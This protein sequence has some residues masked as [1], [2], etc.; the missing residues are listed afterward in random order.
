[1]ERHQSPGV[2]YQVPSNISVYNTEKL[3]E[4][5]ATTELKVTQ[6]ATSTVVPSVTV[7]CYC[8]CNGTIYYIL[9]GCHSF[10]LCLLT[11]CKLLELMKTTFQS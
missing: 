4:T 8:T 1:M 3:G 10:C 2:R 5:W 11:L 9:V 6:V 7:R